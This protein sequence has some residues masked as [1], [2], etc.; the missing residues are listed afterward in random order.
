MF[1]ADHQHT[2]HKGSQQHAGQALGVTGTPSGQHVGGAIHQV[3]SPA[4]SILHTSVGSVS[5]NI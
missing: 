2:R 4:D 3:L 1:A 5:H